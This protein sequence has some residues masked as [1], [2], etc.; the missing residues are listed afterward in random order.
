MKCLDVWKTWSTEHPESTFVLQAKKRMSEYSKDDWKTM[1]AEA[2][3]LME[4]MGYIVNNNLGEL[5]ETIFDR[6]SSHHS[7]WFFNFTRGY[8][9][10][11]IFQSVNS[12]NH[13]EFLNQ[14]APGL[15]L[16]YHRMVRK[17][18]YKVP[19]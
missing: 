13:I 10:I 5:P 3:K 18:A 11:L 15:N 4:D 8:V 12:K 6:L 16:Y 9:N 14:Y 7:D 19:L 1:A 2:T 17:Y